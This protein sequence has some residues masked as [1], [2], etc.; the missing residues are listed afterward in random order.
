MANDDNLN[1]LFWHSRRGMLELD[2]VL[3]PFLEKHY[4]HIS[5]QNKE[6]YAELLKCEDQDLFSWFLSRQKPE[7]PR[8]KQIVDVILEHHQPD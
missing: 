6:Y 5:D 4:Q 3:L 1:K 2:L 8:L 7:D